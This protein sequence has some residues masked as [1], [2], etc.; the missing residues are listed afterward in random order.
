MKYK[1]IREEEL[2]NKIGVDW[3]YVGIDSFVVT[4]NNNKKIKSP[5]TYIVTENLKDFIIDLKNK[6]EKDIWLIGGGQLI[7]TF[8]NEGLWTK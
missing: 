2:K 6:T 4:T 3:P 5:D 7:T 1:N 8:I